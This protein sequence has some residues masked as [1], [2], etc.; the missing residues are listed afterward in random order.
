[1]RLFRNKFELPIPKRR[2]IELQYCPAN[3]RKAPATFTPF[4]GFSFFRWVLQITYFINLSGR[5]WSNE[6][7]TKAFRKNL[8]IA[9]V[10]LPVILISTHYF[11]D[12]IQDC[13]GGIVLNDWVL[14]RLRARDVSMPISFLMASVMFLCLLR[15]V[16]NPTMFLIAIMG[17]TLLFT[18]RIITISCTRLLAP[19]GLI[20]LHDPIC[21]LMYG[22]TFI[23]RDLF[24]S[25]HTATLSFLFLCSYKKIDKYYILFAVVSVGFLLLVQHVHYT[26]DVVCAPVF[27]FGCFWL[28]KKIM[29][30]QGIAIQSPTLRY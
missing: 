26:V 8:I 5:N 1:M 4:L 27:A 10:L 12:F 21:N 30:M 22:S 11:F 9:G 18:A 2:G 19:R 7:H 23:T 28:S 29:N 13:K 25:G 24:F 3:G 15:C 17:F 16:S 6:W 14:Q 20:D